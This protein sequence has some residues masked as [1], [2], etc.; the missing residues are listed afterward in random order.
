MIYITIL[1]TVFVSIFLIALAI[2]LI[3]M[4]KALIE[5]SVFI[6]YH[7]AKIIRPAKK[8]EKKGGSDL[9]MNPFKMLMGG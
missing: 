7:V 8:T 9:M 2:Q 5:T 3:R 4:E 1:L 6:E